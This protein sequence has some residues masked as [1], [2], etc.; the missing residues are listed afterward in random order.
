[1]EAAFCER[2]ILLP[3][4]HSLLAGRGLARAGK[5]GLQPSLVPLGSK[6]PASLPP[7]G[8]LLCL[9]KIVVQF[10]S[11]VWYLLPF[12]PPSSVPFSY[13]F[14]FSRPSSSPPRTSLTPV[15]CMSVHLRGASTVCVYLTSPLGMRVFV[16]VS[17]GLACRRCSGSCD[18]SVCVPGCLCVSQLSGPPTIP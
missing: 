16:S 11:M 18:W 17:E 3:G 7:S 4:G 6:R 13:L 10:T 9:D 8:A 15:F 2:G 12:L 5:A 1:M 14:P